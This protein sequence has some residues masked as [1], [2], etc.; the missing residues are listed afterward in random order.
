MNIVERMK[1]LDFSDRTIRYYRKW[2]LG[3]ARHRPAN[4]I[5]IAVTPELF[6]T[7]AP[8]ANGRKKGDTEKYY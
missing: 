2:P 6:K 7:L 3:R 4:D 5:D 1:D 8:A